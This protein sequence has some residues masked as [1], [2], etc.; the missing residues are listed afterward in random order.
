[1]HLHH[2]L[3]SS[4]LSEREVGLVV[5]I[6][7]LGNDVLTRLM[8]DIVLILLI[9]TVKLCHSFR[10]FQVK[11]NTFAAL[12][13]EDRSARPMTWLLIMVEGLLGLLMIPAFQSRRSPHSHLFKH[14]SVETPPGIRFCSIINGVTVFVLFAF[15]FCVDP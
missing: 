8:L 9:A 7:L 11:V 3:L 13:L 14:L 1:M 5:F 2:P 4:Y 15:Y 6:F 12:A 10:F